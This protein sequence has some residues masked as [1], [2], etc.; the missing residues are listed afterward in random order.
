MLIVESDPWT[1]NHGTRRRMQNIALGRNF[2]R[3]F[4]AWAA[5][6]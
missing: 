5:T 3:T 2:G 4:V 1:T 6:I